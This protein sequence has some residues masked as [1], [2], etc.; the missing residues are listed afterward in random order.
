MKKFTEIV[1]MVPQ[2]KLSMLNNIK[3]ALNALCIMT[4][5]SLNETC[6]IT[7][8]QCHQIMHLTIKTKCM[9]NLKHKK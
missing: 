4:Q 5:C 9:F 3:H 8:L 7:Y 1:N 2:I 6:R